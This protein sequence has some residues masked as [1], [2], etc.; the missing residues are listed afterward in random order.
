M[1]MLERFI[2]QLRET[3]HFFYDANHEK[4]NILLGQ[5]AIIVDGEYIKYNDNC[6]CFWEYSSGWTF[7]CVEKKTLERVEMCK[8]RY[9]KPDNGI[10]IQFSDFACMK[11]QYI[12]TG[13]YELFASN[14]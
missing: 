11:F 14:R 10:I 3:E 9:W 12:R 7:V 13:I 1:T 4:K 8:I 2:S 5:S 6:D